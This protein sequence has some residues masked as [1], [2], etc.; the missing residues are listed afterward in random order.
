MTIHVDM[1]AV[2]QLMVDVAAEE[3]MPRYARLAAGEVRE[4]G[5]GDLVTV[6]D[7]AAE[8]RLTP[9]LA[10]FLPGSVVVGEE[11]AAA[12]PTILKRLEGSQPVWVVDPIDGTANFAEAKGEFAVMISLVQNNQMLASWIYDPR[13]RTMATAERGGGAWLDG[14]RLKVAPAPADPAALT[15]GLLAGFYGDPA[16]GKRV[17]QR[18]NLVRPLKSLRCAAAEYVRIASGV[19]HFLLFSKL[20]PWDHAAGVLL[21][22]EA[23]G[24]NGYVDGGHYLPTRLRAPA[25]ML[26]PD[27][28]SWRQLYQRLIEV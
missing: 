6:A 28:A 5:P 1:D 24:Y 13:Q 8:H 16:L 23:G 10:A 14:K 7:E 19:M 17:Q 4:K 12:D 11:A 15:G 27:E 25:L 3:I 26:A 20:M 21:H 2:G 18:R 9:A 22:A